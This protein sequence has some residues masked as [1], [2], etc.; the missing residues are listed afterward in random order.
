MID[1]EDETTNLDLAVSG[2]SSSFQNILKDDTRQY[3]FKERKAAF[4]LLEDYLACLQKFD[5]E[6]FDELFAKQRDS[7]F[8]PAI[9]A[10]F[11]MNQHGFINNFNLAYLSLPIE[12]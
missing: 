11:Q 7:I 12:H 6:D 1:F 3:F 10:L 8:V 5:S 9:E 2:M 4:Q